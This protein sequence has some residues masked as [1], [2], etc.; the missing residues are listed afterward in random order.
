M[1]SL[2]N[3]GTAG[4]AVSRESISRAWPVSARLIEACKSNSPRRKHVPGVQELLRHAAHRGEDLVR[5]VAAGSAHGARCR[6]CNPLDSSPRAGPDR[7]PTRQVR[8]RC[9]DDAR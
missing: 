9:L 7:P 6:L 4:E 2:N 5:Q 3:S 8:S 1:L